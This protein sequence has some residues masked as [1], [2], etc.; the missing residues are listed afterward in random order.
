M[1]GKEIKT[2]HVPT[3]EP[4]V[5]NLNLVTGD[6]FN[7]DKPLIVKTV[8]TVDR[9]RD[10]I[11]MR[12]LEEIPYGKVSPYTERRGENTKVVNILKYCNLCRQ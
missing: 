8:L 12:G 4:Y 6:K 7:Y 3:D 5:E 9:K 2:H 10:Q 1:K 11:V